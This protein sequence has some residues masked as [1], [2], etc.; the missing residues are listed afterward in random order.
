[1][2][3]KIIWGTILYIYKSFEWKIS[4]KQITWDIEENKGE[5]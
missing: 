4:C 1:M 2:G 3:M 5:Y